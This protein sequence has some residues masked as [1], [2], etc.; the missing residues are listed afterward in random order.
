MIQPAS[1]FKTQPVNPDLTLF[2][3]RE[4]LKSRKFF[5]GLGKV[6][7]DYTPFRPHLDEPIMAAFGLP[8]EENA[9]L[10]FYEQVMDSHAERITE[11]Q[12]I[13]ARE[14]MKVYEVLK[15]WKPGAA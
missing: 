3:I 7:L 12:E 10:D 4:E 8:A 6:G 1:T 15:E 2:L 13:I 14:A 9:V 11:K 5:N